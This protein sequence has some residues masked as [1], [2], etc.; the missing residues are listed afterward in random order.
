M[1]QY[2]LHQLADDGSPHAD[3]ESGWIPLTDDERQTL[4]VGDRIQWHSV[5]GGVEEYVVTH[6]PFWSD[7]IGVWFVM[8][9][10]VHVN[11]AMSLRSAKSIA[12][13]RD[14]KADSMEDA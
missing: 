10:G 5:Y 14:G 1:T 4:K 2:D 12:V 3:S 6:A 13:W 11:H 9:K 8:V 7:Y